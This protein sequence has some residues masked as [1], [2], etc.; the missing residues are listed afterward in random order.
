M[1]LDLTEEQTMLLDTVR[2]FS[3]D[4]LAPV[5]AELDEKGAFP[6]EQVAR[7]SELG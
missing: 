7:M 1:D 2:Q 6:A 5:A 4:E 3:R